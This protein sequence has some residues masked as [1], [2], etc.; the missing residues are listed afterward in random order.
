MVGYTWDYQK[1]TS[2]VV[3]KIYYTENEVGRKIQL[4]IDG[5]TEEYVLDGKNRV[6]EYAD[7]VAVRWGNAYKSRGRGIFGMVPFEG[8]GFIDADGKD[9]EWEKINNYK[10]GN[11][12]N[13]SVLPFYS[14][15]MLLEL[16]ASRA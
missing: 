3:P 8:K 12:Q 11:L 1:R 15:Y 9:S 4:T 13:R 16:N 7:D 10:A 14:E 6:T 2:S 5:K